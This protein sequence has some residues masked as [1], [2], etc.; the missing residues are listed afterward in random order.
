[1]CFFAAKI[2]YS[3]GY[4][5]RFKKFEFDYSPCFKGPPFTS[6]YQSVS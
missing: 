1:M 5:V 3:K 4:L 6:P 2:P